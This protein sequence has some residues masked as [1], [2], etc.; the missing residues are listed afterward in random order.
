MAEAALLTLS[1]ERQGE[2][3]FNFDRG[4]RVEVSDQ[5]WNVLRQSDGHRSMSELL[6]EYGVR[7]ELWFSCVEEIAGLW[8]RRFVQLSFDGATRAP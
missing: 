6:E 7:R 5:V 1:E 8:D 4:K 3:C 2:V